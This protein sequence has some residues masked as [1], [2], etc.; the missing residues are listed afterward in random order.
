VWVCPVGSPAAL[1]APRK[2]TV[3]VW[4]LGEQEPQ[5]NREKHN[6]QRTVID[7]L[8]YQAILPP[9]FLIKMPINIVLTC[10]ITPNCERSCSSVARQY[11]SQ[12]SYFYNRRPFFADVRI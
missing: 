11:R 8:I 4:T 5:T 7:N 12:M 3:A 9:I 1:D 6:P 2:T 10:V